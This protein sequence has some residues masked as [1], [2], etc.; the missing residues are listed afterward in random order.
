[1]KAKVNVLDILLL[2]LALTLT[3]STASVFSACD[4][5]EDGSWMTCHWANRAVTV[6]GGVAALL[7]ILRLCIPSKAKFGADL[8]LICMA[9]ATAAIPNRIIPMCMM[10]DMRC[11]RVFEPAVLVLSALIGICAIIDALLRAKER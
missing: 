11:H 4:P 7:S 1:M 5:M 9:I 6:V 10:A 2:L 8:G 3:I